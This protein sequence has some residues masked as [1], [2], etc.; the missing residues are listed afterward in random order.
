MFRL[1]LQKAIVLQGDIHFQD[2]ARKADE[3]EEKDRYIPVP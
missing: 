2:D 3:H 1:L